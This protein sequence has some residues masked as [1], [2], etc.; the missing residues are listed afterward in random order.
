M[1]DVTE[2]TMPRGSATQMPHF[3]RSIPPSRWLLFAGS[4][5]ALLLA[6]I[7]WLSETVCAINTPNGCAMYTSF[8]MRPFLEFLAQQ[9]SLRPAIIHLLPFAPYLLITCMAPGLLCSIWVR[10]PIRS[11]GQRIGVIFFSLWFLLLTAASIYTPYWAMNRAL[12]LDAA[13]HIPSAWGPTIGTFLVVPTLIALWIG[14][15]L[16]WR[17]LL[18]RRDERDASAMQRLNVLEYIG[19]GLATGGM[20]V[21]FIAYYGLY[22]LLPPD[23]PPTPLFGE[24][25]CNERFGSGEG[26]DQLF[27]QPGGY[28][29]SWIFYGT[30]STVIVFGGLALLVALW[31][32][33]TSG[34]ELI[35]IGAWMFCLFLLTGLSIY[36]TTR[37]VPDAPGDVWTSG[38]WVTLVGVALIAA[39]VVMRWRQIGPSQARHVL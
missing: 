34:K 13:N 29:V 14:L 16:T 36:G 25:A 19:A 27:P 20:L 28:D 3:L 15:L 22:W 7:P 35:G 39:G 11:T 1:A 38:V 10:G 2:D 17:D 26:F 8:D 4:L 9:L 21:W 23:C 5:G 24:A 30:L 37:I 31:L 6:F 32:R 33:R 18:R 12:A